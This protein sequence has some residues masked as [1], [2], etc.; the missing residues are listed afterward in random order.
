MNQI[1]KNPINH[2]RNSKN[3]LSGETLRDPPWMTTLLVDHPI[4]Q[5]AV[6][7]RNDRAEGG[8]GARAVLEL[9]PDEL[10]VEDLDRLHLARLQVVQEVGVRDLAREVRVLQKE[11]EDEE[12]DEH[13]QGHQGGPVVEVEPRV[14]RIVTVVVWHLQL[15]LSTA[16]VDGHE[17][18]SGGTA[19]IGDICTPWQGEHRDHPVRVRD[20]AG[21]VARLERHSPLAQ[22]L[23]EAR[24]PGCRGHPVASTAGADNDRRLNAGPADTDR[25]RPAV[26]RLRPCFPRRMG[27]QPVRASPLGS[28]DRLRYQSKIACF[29]GADN[30]PGHEKPV[31]AQFNAHPGALQEPVDRARALVHQPLD[32]AIGQPCPRGGRAVDDPVQRLGAQRGRQRVEGIRVGGKACWLDLPDVAAGK[33]GVDEAR[34][35]RHLPREAVERPRVPGKDLAQ[36][37]DEARPDPVAE[38]ALVGVGRI[39]ME[40]LR[41]L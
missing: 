32:G 26:L 21:I 11:E 16:A 27:P 30:M 13:Q 23:L 35:V 7:V 37:R 5:V 2:G 38:E 19:P 9:A 3:T 18:P 28:F 24:C 31:F 25:L 10:A 39:R 40:A 8:H 34:Q 41:P 20:D 6:E 33:L 14:L 22:E 1:K 29:A 12:A 15:R 36:D 4:D 17:A